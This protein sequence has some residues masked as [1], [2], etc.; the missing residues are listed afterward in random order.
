[1]QSKMSAMSAQPTLASEPEERAVEWEAAIRLPS[2]VELTRSRRRFVVPAAVG[3]FAW[4]VAWLMLVA[5]APGLMGTE[6]VRGV[7]VMLVTGLS[8]FVVVWALTWW[9]LRRARGV[10]APLQRR[11][12]EELEALRAG[13]RR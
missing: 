8:Q 6:I 11:A 5:Y 13:E 9:Y 12:I 2:F 4:I 10:W 7:S 3:A 1:M